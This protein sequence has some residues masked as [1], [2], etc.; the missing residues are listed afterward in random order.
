MPLNKKAILDDIF[1][2]NPTLISED[3]C[4]ENIVIPFLLRLGYQNA[5]I[6]RKVTISGINVKNLKN[7]LI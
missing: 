7:K 6:R 5:Q 3:D 1:R 4:A 2:T